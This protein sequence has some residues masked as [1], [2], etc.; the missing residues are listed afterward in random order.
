[1]AFSEFMIS[2]LAHLE[3]LRLAGSNAGA[4][5]HKRRQLNRI[6]QRLP[7]KERF[8]LE[9][10]GRCS[11]GRASLTASA[12]PLS[13]WPL[14][15]LIAALACPPSFIVMNAKPRDLPLNRSIIKLTS[16]TVPCCSNRSEEHTSEL[17]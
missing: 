11:R 14:S 15:A 13:S 5:F 1:M 4:R 10:R 6:Y 7:A 3:E 16:L 8:P 17:Q 12:R 2:I 9:G